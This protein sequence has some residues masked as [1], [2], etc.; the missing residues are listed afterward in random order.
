[1]AKWYA[2]EIAVKVADEVLQ[3]HGGYG[4]LGESD[5]TAL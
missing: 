3:I 4:Y 2:G 1:M 5:R